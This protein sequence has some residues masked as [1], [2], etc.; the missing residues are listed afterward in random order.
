MTRDVAALA[1]GHRAQE[2]SAVQ[3]QE[4]GRQL[5]RILGIEG[6]RPVDARRRVPLPILALFV[7]RQQRA[8][9]APEVPVE[10]GLEALRHAPAAR[11]RV[12]RVLLRLVRVIVL[13]GAHNGARADAR[14]ELRTDLADFR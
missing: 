8:T 11:V 4:L 6:L 9:A 14:H 12:A 10:H 7:Q 5:L 3:R 2:R 1:I 13:A